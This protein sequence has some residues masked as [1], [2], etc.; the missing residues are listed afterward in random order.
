MF[1]HLIVCL[2]FASDS[3][4]HHRTTQYCLVWSRIRIPFPSVYLWN[5]VKYPW[6]TACSL[7]F[8][9]TNN[10]IP[11]HMFLKTGYPWTVLSNSNGL[12]WFSRKQKPIVFFFLW[13]TPCSDTPIDVVLLFL[14]HVGWARYRSSWHR[15]CRSGCQVDVDVSGTKWAT[16]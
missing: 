15:W 4:E 6:K 5:C 10:W 12:S 13:Y 3:M 16:P 7:T 2:S 9:Q 1:Y 14:A 8:W 11:S